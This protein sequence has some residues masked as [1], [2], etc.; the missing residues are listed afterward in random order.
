[1]RDILK[2]IYGLE[3]KTINI[4]S[5]KIVLLFSNYWCREGK[6]SFF[7]SIKIRIMLL[8]LN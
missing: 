2:F 6:D 1:M 3:L 7:I 5:H 4:Y 8:K